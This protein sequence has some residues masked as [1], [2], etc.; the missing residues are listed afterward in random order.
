MV[1]GRGGRQVGLGFPILCH[2]F[3]ALVGSSNLKLE[4][5]TLHQNGAGQNCFTRGSMLNKFS[6]FF[7]FSF[8]IFSFLSLPVF[9]QEVDTAWVRTYIGPGNHEDI[10][11]AV[12][13][14]KAGNVYV[15]GYSK[16]IGTSLDYVTIKYHGNGDTA[17]LRRYNGSGSHGD[18]AYAIAVDSSGNVYITGESWGEGTYADYAT[19]KYDSVG[20]QIWVRTYNGPGLSPEDGAYAMVLDLL[21]N[22]YVTGYSWGSGT[23]RDYATIKYYPN[24]DTAWVRRYDGTGHCEDWAYALALDTYGNVYVTG[25][26]EGSGTHYDCTTVKYDNNGNEM[27]VRRYN[28][29]RSDNDEAYAIAIDDSSNVYVTGVVDDYQNQGDYLTIKYF[30]NGDTAWVRRYNSYVGSGAD[31]ACA[32]SFDASGNVYVTGTVGYTMIGSAF[33]TIKYYPNGDTAWTRVYS[34]EPIGSSYVGARGITV[35]AL[36]NVYVVGS[37][38]DSSGERVY[39]TVKYDS[40]GNQLWVERYSGMPDQ[41][42]EP[43]DIAVDDYGNVY[44]TGYTQAVSGL[45]YC[46]VKYWQNFAPDS[47]S[48]LSP[49]DSGFVLSG[50]MTFD[51]Q[52]AIDPDPWDTVR[53]DLYVSSSPAFHPDSTVIHDSLLVNQHTDT[54]DIGTH[55]WKVRAYDK[56]T[57]VWSNQTW[58]FYVFSA[59]DFFSLISPSK[60][61][62]VKSPVTLCWHMAKDLDPNDTVRYDLYLSRDSLFSTK[63]TVI[64]D[65]LLDTTLILNLDI[66]PW[67]WKVKAYDK[68]GA[69]RWSNQTDWSFY[70][71]LCGDC[72]GDGT[73]NVSDV[74]YL[75]NYLF[76]G[77][78]A[79]VPLA[80][81]DVNCDRIVNVSDVVYLINYLFI[82]GPPPGC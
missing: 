22:I 44:V 56:H 49:A 25:K 79:P 65:S 74:V 63:S 52:D 27:W 82:G 12:T 43:Y 59:P 30:P 72:N 54:L 35:D 53:Y 77:G 24:G 67:Y 8:S 73:I 34:H 32:I 45:S 48:L 10:A 70:V 61:D 40:D 80:A 76:I 81:G 64:Y 2:H 50:A 68:W 33:L 16:G 71:Y 14:D 23:C 46:T 1:H 38:Y 21:G 17:W 4:T 6:L 78:P 42:D 57:E 28:G 9:A 15:T 58:S 13:L 66:G 7:I 37:S 3:W 18:M 55:Y 31:K 41:N 26:S 39:A 47:F 29:T 69:E 36:N 51:W 60:D 11:R 20:N 62:S 5:Q 75:I 19:V